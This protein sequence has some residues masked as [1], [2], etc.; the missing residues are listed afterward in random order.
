MYKLGNKM[1]YVMKKKAIITC[2]VTLHAQV[3]KPDP[4]RILF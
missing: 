4:D 2:N 1:I 3:S